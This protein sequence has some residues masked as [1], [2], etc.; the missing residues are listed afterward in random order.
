MTAPVGAAVGPIRHDLDARWLM[1]YAAGLG[2]H[3][4]RYSDTLSSIDQRH[5]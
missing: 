4:L 5:V 1:A 2:E 3:D